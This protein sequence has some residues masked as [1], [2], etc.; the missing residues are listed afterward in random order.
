M[1]S[2]G[3][4]LATFLAAF[5]LI[6]A[7]AAGQTLQ[8][9]KTITASG[10]GTSTGGSLTMESTAGQPSAGGVLTGASGTAYIGFWTPDLAPTAAGVSVSGRATSAGQGLANIIVTLANAN[11]DI[12]MARTGPFG[13]Y[14]FDQVPVGNTYLLTASSKQYLFSNSPRVISVHDEISDMDLIAIEP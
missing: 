4:R 11:G 7:V 5:V 1:K 10:G 14:R 3:H 2:T 12:W 8:L 13:Y 9:E 6:S